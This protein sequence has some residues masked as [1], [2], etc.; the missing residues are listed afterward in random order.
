MSVPRARRYSWRWQHWEWLVR[1][2]Q[3]SGQ[4]KA[5]YCR[6]HDL[7]PWQ[8]YSWCRRVTERKFNESTGFALVESASKDSGLCL[9]LGRGM[10]LRLSRDFDES[11]L[12]RLLSLSC[13]SC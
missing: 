13:W 7:R 11:T 8:F 2:W 10:E 6:A 12:S 9:H 5:A 3:G 4:S 1:D